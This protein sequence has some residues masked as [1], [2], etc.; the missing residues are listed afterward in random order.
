VGGGGIWIE[1]SGTVQSARSVIGG[2]TIA[3]SG[4]REFGPDCRG[5]M[6]SIGYTALG[7]S[8]DCTLLRAPGLPPRSA[9]SVGIDPRLGELQDNGDAGYAH[10]PVLAGSPLIDAG[11]RV[12]KLCAPRDQIGRPR[13]DGD[14]NATVRCDIGA[15]EYQP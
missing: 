10:L 5:T 1:G 12:S 13:V 15:I 6:T 14:S 4:P 11:G 2:N 8:T 7:D 9:D 3:G